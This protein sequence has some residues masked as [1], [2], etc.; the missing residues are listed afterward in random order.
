MIGQQGVALGEYKVPVKIAGAGE[1]Q[2]CFYPFKIEPY[3]RGCSHNCLYC[4]SRSCNDFRGQWD[5][6]RPYVT[7]LET[8]R[9]AFKSALYYGKTSGHM[10]KMIR[11][12]VP[13]RIG[14]FT[15]C[16]GAAETKWRNTR[17]LVQM[18]NSL[19][20]PYM[21][22]TKSATVL[23]DADLLDPELC[24]AQF[25]VTTP[26]DAEARVMEPGASTT[27]ERLD[28]IRQLAGAGFTTATPWQGINVDYRD[29]NVESQLSDEGSLLNYYKRLIRVRSAY[30][31][32]RTGELLPVLSSDLS[33]YAYIRHGETEDVLVVHNV[34]SEAMTAVDLTVR[35]SDLAPGRYRATD[36]L[37]GVKAEP[38]DIDGKGAFADYAPAQ[39]LEPGQTMILLLQAK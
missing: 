30:E 39:T 31:A 28:A 25:S 15:D 7:K 34:S 19:R 6:K 14:S 9:K 24:Y 37:S 27:S 4:Y 12:H 18:L 13:V 36:L 23:E 3:G 10:N 33:V 29:R 26:D 38:L 8:I 5:P 1:A 16:Y 20:Y 22:M 32:L 2:R 35:A 17:K 11:A 21:V